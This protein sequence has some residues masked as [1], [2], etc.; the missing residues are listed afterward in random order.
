M[1]PEYKIYVN[2]NQIDDQTDSNIIV[3]M[4]FFESHYGILT[5]K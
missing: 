4:K 1:I 3:I 2:Q 5:I